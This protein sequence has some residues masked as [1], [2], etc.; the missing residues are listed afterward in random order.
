[1]RTGFAIAIVAGTFKKFWVVVFGIAMILGSTLQYLLINQ[2]IKNK[3]NPDVPILDYIPVIYV[4][5]SLGTLYL[6]W[7]K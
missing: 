6:Q 5:L 4:I 7:K 1:M 2:R 3:E